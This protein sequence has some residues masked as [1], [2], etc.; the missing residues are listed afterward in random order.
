MNMADKSPGWTAG[1]RLAAIDQAT[2]PPLPIITDDNGVMWTQDDRLGVQV[3]P[4]MLRL[5]KGR[6]FQRQ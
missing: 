6:F 3:R 5:P 2:P 1:A 4:L